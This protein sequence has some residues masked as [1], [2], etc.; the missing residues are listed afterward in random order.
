MNEHFKSA[1][2]LHEAQLS[3]SLLGELRSDGVKAKGE[4]QG[5]CLPVGCRQRY[6]TRFDFGTDN[7]HHICV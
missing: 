4:I 7:V 5:R 6:R 1:G 3:L 2:L